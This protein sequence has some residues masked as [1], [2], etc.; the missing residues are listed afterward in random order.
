[1]CIRERNWISI[2]QGR[3]HQQNCK[4][5]HVHLRLL[6]PIGSRLRICFFLLDDID[7]LGVSGIVSTT[8]MPLCRADTTVYRTYSIL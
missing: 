1:M 3:P 5:G 8:I 2:V 6:V 7:C 4:T